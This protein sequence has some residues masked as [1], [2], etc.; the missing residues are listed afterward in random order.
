MLGS[1]MRKFLDT[2]SRA[3]LSTK[4][5]AM[6]AAAGALYGQGLYVEMGQLVMAW[7]AAQGISEHGK[8]M[9]KPAGVGHKD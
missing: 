7:L 5:L 8:G 9:G 4:F 3:V 2:L 1:D 6:V